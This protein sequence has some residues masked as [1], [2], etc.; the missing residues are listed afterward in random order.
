M[1]DRYDLGFCRSTVET[2]PFP[3]SFS[4]IALVLIVAVANFALGFAAAAFWRKHLSAE[5][6]RANG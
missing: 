5:P 6:P 3:A 1:T 2:K 4:M